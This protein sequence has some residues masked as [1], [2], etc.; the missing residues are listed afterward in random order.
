MTAAGRSAKE[1]AWTLA[2]V[3]SSYTTNL[4]V[5]HHDGYEATPASNDIGMQ[6]SIAWSCRTVLA[7]A[8][9]LKRG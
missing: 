5:G 4:G 6:A 7:T 1:T 8:R 9:L 3:S 2:V